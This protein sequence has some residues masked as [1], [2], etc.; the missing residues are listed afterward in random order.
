ME[1][2]V[3]VRKP[4]VSFSQRATIAKLEKIA[5]TRGTES[6]PP[7]PNLHV[8]TPGKFKGSMTTRSIVDSV[9][10]ES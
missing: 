4:K 8:K 2:I 7:N 10:N 1:S 6:E 9:A 3:G 5:E